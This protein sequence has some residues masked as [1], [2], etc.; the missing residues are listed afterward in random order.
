MRTLY[1]SIGGPLA[2]LLGAN[3]LRNPAFFPFAGDAIDHAGPQ[4]PRVGAEGIDLTLTPAVNSDLGAKPLE[5]VV[6]FEAKQGAEWV[7]AAY[8]IK[9]MPGTGSGISDSGADS[10][11]L[12]AALG[13][14]LIG[15]L[16]LNV[17]PCVFPVLSIKALSLARGNENEARRHGF[18][19]LVGVLAT[20]LALAGAL[21]ALQAAGAQVGWGFQL[22]EPLVVAALGLLFFAIALNLLGAYEF[23]GGVQSLGA[24]LADRGGDIGAFFTGAL[25]VIAATPC[26]APFMGAAMGFAATQPAAISLL[27]FT[28][29]GLGF[30]LPFVLI[31]LAPSLRKMLPK[32]GAWMETFKQFLA[33][34]MFAAA[35]WLAWVLTQQAGANGLLA[36]LAAFLGLAFVIWAARALKKS[37][38]RWVA[39]ALGAALIFAAGFGV[40]TTSASTKVGAAT[41]TASGLTIEPWS[42]ARVDALRAE[43]KA[44]FVDF[45]AAWCVTCQVN[46]KVAL[47][48]PQVVDAFRKAGVVFLKADWTKRDPAI[49]EALKSHGRAGVP[50]YLYYPAAPAGAPPKILPQLLT[51]GLVVEAIGRKP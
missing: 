37:G 33:F 11:G 39:I 51:P 34:P 24:G 42:P 48:T 38:A 21:I 4:K 45:T 13:F 14:A 36:L 31:S 27:V 8:E 40:T 19:F 1:Y 16:I 30:A 22:Q 7:P 15:G 35:A 6:T 26:T 25:A 20:F 47:E 43:G 41:T 9:A 17:M 12:V 5:G 18:F 29:L 50:L 28:A 32:P 3:A 44:V 10:L 46:E 2:P 23:G 49:A